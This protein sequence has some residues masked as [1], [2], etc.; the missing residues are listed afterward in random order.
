MRG[1]RGLRG[2]L[3]GYAEQVLAEQ[4]WWEPFLIHWDSGAATLC[5]EEAATGTQRCGAAPRCTP[6][7]DCLACAGE[8]ACGLGP[9][10]CTWVQV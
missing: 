1:L 2:E 5:V 10:T 9:G 6:L 3:W 4:E 8:Q 7:A